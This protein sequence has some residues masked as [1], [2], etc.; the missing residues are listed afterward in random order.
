MQEHLQRNAAAEGIDFARRSLSSQLVNTHRALAASLHAQAEEPDR[1]EAF[2]HALFRANFSEMRNI[3]EPAVLRDIASAAGL[4]LAR[5]DAAL[6]TG[7]G[8]SAFREAAA[9]AHRHRITA[10]PAFVFGGNRVIVGAHPEAALVQAAEDA[11]A[12]TRGDL[13]RS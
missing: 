5:L 7:A 3:G 6:E 8:D 1:F 10:I 2:H 9:E 4:D 13:R 12:E 11:A